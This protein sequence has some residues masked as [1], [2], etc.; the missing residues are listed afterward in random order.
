MDPFGAMD[1]QI[2][3]PVHSP[4]FTIRSI[5]IMIDPQKVGY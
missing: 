5:E 2:P 1:L 4:D 3:Q